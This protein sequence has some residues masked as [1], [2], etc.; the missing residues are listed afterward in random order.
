[1]KNLNK[2]KKFEHHFYLNQNEQEKFKELL[3]KYKVKNKS[4]FLAS[5]ILNRKI[6]T[7]FIDPI[8]L[9]YHAKLTSLILHF[10]AF[11]VNYNRLVVNNKQTPLN[12]DL[13]VEISK[14][15]LEFSKLC[16]QIITLTIE[17]ERKLFDR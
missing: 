10:K 9:Q 1:M 11:G 7:V 12:K 6:E 8:A 15:T 13:L 5:Y 16:R 2:G 14:L 4:K 3:L 17:F